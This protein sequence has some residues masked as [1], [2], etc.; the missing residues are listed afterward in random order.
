VPSG[1]EVRRVLGR[2]KIT[3]KYDGCAPDFTPG[4][5]IIN[6]TLELEKADVAMEWC[7]D[8]F[9]NALA[10]V[11]GNNLAEEYLRSGVDSMDP[12]GTQVESWIDQLVTDGVRRD[13]WRQMS[14]ADSAS[15]DED[16]NII[17]GI[18]PK[19]LSVDGS[20]SSYCVQGIDTF[21]KEATSDLAD[22][23]AIEVLK[24]VYQDSK[25]ILKQY[26]QSRRYMMVTGTVYENLLSS[27][28]ANVNGTERQFTNLVSGQAGED[29]QLPLFYRGIPIVPSY[30]WD[31]ALEDT[32]NP[33]YDQVRHLI[34]Y[35]TPDNQAIG[36]HDDVDAS[37]LRG[38]FSNDDGVY[39]VRGQHRMGY[40]FIHCDLTTIAY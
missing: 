10:A 36:L 20:G 21:P 34:L 26:P 38:W 2:S 1:L 32:T 3:K 17:D 27:Y 4:T 5:D 35:T 33:L 39:R 7:V 6:R 12:Q 23:Q 14:F 9:E 31:T 15:M 22:G 16:W 30:A 19:L 11:A 37:R 28:E 40:T 8:D 25:N 18:W 24:K 13:F 29:G